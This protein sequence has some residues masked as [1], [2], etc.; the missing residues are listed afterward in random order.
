MS[1]PR[2]ATGHAPPGSLVTPG[3]AD[4]HAFSNG[5]GQQLLHGPGS[6]APV[7]SQ[8]ELEHE[9]HRQIPWDQDDHHESW[10][11]KQPAVAAAPTGLSLKRASTTPSEHYQPAPISSIVAAAATPSFRPHTPQL[12]ERDSIFATHYLPS[13]NNDVSSA[14]STPLLRPVRESL[15]PDKETLLKS[16][17]GDASPASPVSVVSPDTAVSATSPSNEDNNNN[18]NN[19]KTNTAI[20]PS[21]PASQ[22]TS[23][24]RPSDIALQAPS[25]PLAGSHVGWVKQQETVESSKIAGTHRIAIRETFHP[26]RKIASE[27]ND[28]EPSSLTAHDHP[29]H[30]FLPP[31]S[32]TPRPRLHNIPMLD[33]SNGDHEHSFPDPWQA[34]RHLKHGDGTIDVTWNTK[35]NRSTS[36]GRATRVEE[37]IEADLT[38]TEPASHVRSR[39]SSHY[40]GLFKENT[41]PDR[42]RRDDRER[43][44]ENAGIASGHELLEEADPES[45]STPRPVHAAL[46][47]PPPVDDDSRENVLETED[48]VQEPEDTEQVLSVD[49][50]E[51]S[52]YP[53]RTIPRGLSEEIRNFHLTTGGDRGGSFSPSVPTRFTKVVRRE[54]RDFYDGDQSPRS[55]IDH[56]PP[57]GQ[58][59]RTDL[60]EL[61]VD[62]DEDEHISSALYF[63]HEAAPSATEPSFSKYRRDEE[64]YTLAK[65]DVAKPEPTTNHIDISLHSQKDSSILHGDFSALSDAEEKALATISEYSHES[66][67]ESEAESTLSTQDEVSSLTDDAEHLAMTPTQRPL[68]HRRKHTKTGLLGAVELKP[69]RHQVGGHTTV[70]RFSRRAVCKQ[71]NNR[72]NEFY[73]RI[74]RRHPEMLMFLPRF[75]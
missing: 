59:C 50:S 61:V 57:S 33:S 28:S 66:T 36:R 51:L 34:S 24:R 49:T 9:R 15:R 26:L 52:P 41:S 6:A 58:V 72:E 29:E 7:H 3:A 45:P 39:K 75:V 17:R 40:L 25:S 74:E 27:G 44:L 43:Q 22:S 56:S 63:P 20:S 64:V 1:R 73:E 68:R 4:S 70:F 55:L 11:P 69:Y 47:Q 19:N 31:T 62:E 71:L 21:K 42:K 65:Q 8:P 13:D 35:L 38:N 37:S 16:S 60:G 23:F 48:I 10:S 12:S 46:Y 67:S 18:N 14:A 53:F 5:Q 30:S 32:A 54:T 2:S